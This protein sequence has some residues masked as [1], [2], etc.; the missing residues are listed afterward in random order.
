MAIPGMGR[1]ELVLAG[2]NYASSGYLR[3]HP[4]RSRLQSNGKRN[5]LPLQLE[6]CKDGKTSIFDLVSIGFGVS[7]LQD[8]NLRQYHLVG[9]GIFSRLGRLQIGMLHSHRQ[10]I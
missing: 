6:L 10:Q 2:L 7:V 1:A 3:V 9:N 4:C 5:N 8:T